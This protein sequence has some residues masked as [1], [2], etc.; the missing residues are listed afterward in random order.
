MHALNVAKEEAPSPV[1]K[2]ARG[3]LEGRPVVEGIVGRLGRPFWHPLDSGPCSAAGGGGRISRGLHL[4]TLRLGLGLALR[5]VHADLFFTGLL[6]RAQRLGLFLLLL[7]SLSEE[8]GGHESPFLR[9]G[10]HGGHVGALL[11]HG[12]L[13]LVLIQ[14]GLGEPLRRGEGEVLQR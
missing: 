7:L 10:I 13:L 4:T 5:D 11:H 2:G 9:R 6:L 8:L 3:T 14:Q 1:A 12:A